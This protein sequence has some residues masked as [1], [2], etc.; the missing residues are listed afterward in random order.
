MIRDDLEEE[1]KESFEVKE[2]LNIEEFLDQRS[3]EKEEVL[4]SK[5]GKI[6]SKNSVLEDGDEITVFDVIAGG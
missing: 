6:V 4:V 2:G 1:R 5:D 3:I